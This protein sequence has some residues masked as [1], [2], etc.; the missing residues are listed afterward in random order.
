[1]LIYQG[2]TT[3][4]L[5]K[6]TATDVKLQEGKIFVPGSRCSNSRKL[7][8]KPFLVMYL[9]EYINRIRPGLIIEPTDQL[10]LNY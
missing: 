4:G 5:M 3:V 9:Y 6:L 1:M 8:F 7:E 2:I 10:F